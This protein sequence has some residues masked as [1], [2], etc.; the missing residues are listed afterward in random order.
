MNIFNT[1]YN[2][3]LKEN[4]EQEKITLEILNF[5]KSLRARIANFGNFSNDNEFQKEHIR[6]MINLNQLMQRLQKTNQNELLSPLHTISVQ[7]MKSGLNL[8]QASQRNKVGSK[9]IDELANIYFD[10]MKALANLLK[11]MDS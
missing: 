4:P 2:Q 5:I 11:N 3:V 6:I 1:I 8:I 7:F 10:H 9:S